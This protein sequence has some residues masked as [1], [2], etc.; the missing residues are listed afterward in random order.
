M[1]QTNPDL[2]IVYIA[3]N[4]HSG[5]TLLDMIIG[6][7]PKCFRAG[8]ITHFARDG[9]SH[10][11]CSCGSTVRNCEVWQ[12]VYESWKTSQRLT[13]EDYHQLDFRFERNKTLPR[14]LK[15]LISPS[16]DFQAYIES[17]ETLFKAIQ[18][19]TG[20]S[21]IVDSSKSAARILILGSFSD[22]KVLHLTRKFTG[23]MHSLTRFHPRDLTKGVRVHLHPTRPLRALRD[24]VLNNALVLVLSIGV[25]RHL[26]HYSELIRD[27]SS[28]LSM[29]DADFSNI[30]ER[31][32]APPHMIAGNMI[33]L[34]KDVRLDPKIGT[35]SAS[36]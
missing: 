32:L 14:L 22:V 29:F 21:L 11:Y 27:P 26:I 12:S 7:A 16:S 6:S 23:V 13:V 25:E 2:S 36:R 20:A 18:A 28:V 4:G 33:R 9:I 34:S 19:V 35:T 3:G 15:N 24:W 8:E 5:S 1:S 30:T 17:T 31:N 10:E